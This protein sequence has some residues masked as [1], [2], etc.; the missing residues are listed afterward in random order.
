MQTDNGFDP[1]DSGVTAMPRATSVANLHMP[2]NLMSG[3]KN[4]L[5]GKKDKRKTMTV[6]TISAPVALQSS[7]KAQH[8]FT[9]AQYE[10]SPIPKVDADL[11]SESDEEEDSDGFATP[12]GHLK[13][14][15]STNDL[16]STM[17]SKP[18]RMSTLKELSPEHKALDLA[19]A[20]GVNINLANR[21]PVTRD[22][23]PTTPPSSDTDS[24]FPPYVPPGLPDITPGP[25]PTIKPAGAAAPLDNP[26]YVR[27]ITRGMHGLHMLPNVMEF[28]GPPQWYLD[29]L[30]EDPN[31]PP[32][33]PASGVTVPN[34][35]EHRY[36]NQ[37]NHLVTKAFD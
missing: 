32:P 20:G 19:R 33:P 2:R 12:Y 34:D 23:K 28:A 16:P 35:T 15:K 31:P 1:P 14:A 10:R 27:G 26:K 37:S 29:G 6:P 18:N 30:K 3:V 25:A 9:G 24:V 36:V 8:F 17:F 11:D 21:K 22:P 13:P 7:P 4:I 5:T